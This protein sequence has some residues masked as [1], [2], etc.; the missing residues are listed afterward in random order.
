MEP[1]L[2]PGSTATRNTQMARPRVTKI[3]LGNLRGS[4]Y[5]YADG[6][7]LPEHTHN[8]STNHLTIVTNGRLEVIGATDR[9]GRVLSAGDVLEWEPCVSHGMRAL[10][11]SRMVNLLIGQP[12]TEQ[13]HRTSAPG[14][15]PP[16]ARR[17]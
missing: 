17:A 16:P 13:A 3:R 15:T 4:I 14:E 1:G 9:A 7:V 2:M 11:P 12:G 8:E 6:D 10:E 5:D